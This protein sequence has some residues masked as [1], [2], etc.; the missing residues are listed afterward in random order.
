MRFEN[1]GRFIFWTV[2]FLIGGSIILHFDI[3]VPYIGKWIG[4][5]PGDIL[6]QK[7]QTIIYF[8]LTSAAIAGFLFTVV[9][10]SLTGKRQET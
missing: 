2:M 10:A 1:L 7:G 6:L 3:N 5:L 9:L 4:T 8:P